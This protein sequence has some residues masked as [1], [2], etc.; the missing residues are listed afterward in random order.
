MFFAFEKVALLDLATRTPI[1][2]P[3]SE[4]LSGLTW[5]G[6]DRW[7]GRSRNL[8]TVV[9]WRRGDRAMTVIAKPLHG[10]AEYAASPGRVYVE[11]GGTLVEYSLDDVSIERILWTDSSG[12]REVVHTA[13]TLVVREDECVRRLDAASRAKAAP[14][15][16]VV[17]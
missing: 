14:C 7:V 16:L 5:V 10:F 11:A 3:G 6:P 2:V 4:Q 8:K 9:T 15:H 17:D 13:E 12:V 1:E